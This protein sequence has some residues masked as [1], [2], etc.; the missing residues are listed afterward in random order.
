MCL[1]RKYR[2]CLSSDSEYYY[3]HLLLRIKRAKQSCYNRSFSQ[4]SILS[5]VG[6]AEAASAAAGL[7]VPT[8]RHDGRHR[9]PLSGDSSNDSTAADAIPPVLPAVSAAAA[10]VSALFFGAVM[11]I[12]IVGQLRPVSEG[13][14]AYKGMIHLGTGL[15]TGV[16]AWTAGRFLSTA[17]EAAD[18]R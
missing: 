15:N 17:T 9:H 5:L 10:S 18:S 11:S 1:V 8:P 14:F 16:T 4:S 2:H 13:Y 3:C 7:L 6:A 12:K